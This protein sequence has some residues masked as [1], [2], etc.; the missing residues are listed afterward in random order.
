MI[1]DLRPTI[2]LGV[3]TIWNDLL[4]AAA[5]QPDADLSSL[6]RI[7]A[8]GAAVPRFMI[9]AF[10][11]R[12]GVN[13][14]QGWGMTETSPLV[15]VSVPPRDVSA[16]EEIDYRA[17][18]GRVMAGVEIRLTNDEGEVLARDGVARGSSNYADPGLRRP[19]TAAS[20][21]SCSAT[22]GCVAATS[23]PWT[24]GGTW[25]SRTGPRT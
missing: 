14:L 4:R 17:K 21:P 20:H 15:A 5:E 19:T 6:E 11:D 12:Y 8:G 2:A 1:G 9:E 18:A 10:R 24:R 13:V 23:A 25:S 3:P 22:V 7:L 16:S